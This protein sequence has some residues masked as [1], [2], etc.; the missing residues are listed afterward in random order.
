MDN[1]LLIARARHGD[2]D[3]GSEILRRIVN[4]IDNG[5]FDYRLFTFLA[6]RLW[7]HIEKALPLDVALCV[8]TKGT[9]GRPRIYD[10]IELAAVDILL[11]KH[12]GFSGKAAD[13]WITDKSGNDARAVQK[14]RREFAPMEAWARDDLLAYCGTTLRKPLIAE[15]RNRGRNK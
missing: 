7:E 5:R 13:R 11:R 1:E 8:A 12:A 10:D 4:A 9:R 14:R 6:E 15:I 3:A 2:A